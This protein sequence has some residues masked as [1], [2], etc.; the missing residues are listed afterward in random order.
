MYAK[1]VMRK[2]L[3]SGRLNTTAGMLHTSSITV[4]TQFLELTCSLCNSQC[5]SLLGKFDLVFFLP[6][7]YRFQSSLQSAFLVC[8]LRAVRIIIIFCKEAGRAFEPLF[9]QEFQ[10]RSQ[11]N[12]IPAPEP[13]FSALIHFRRGFAML[14][15]SCPS[16]PAQPVNANFLRAF[17]LYK[18]IR[19]DFSA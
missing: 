4:P 1:E 11:K 8:A 6:R 14:C 17:V 15:G 16:A 10:V 7:S 3:A 9:E 12:V 5:C 13:R 2:V 18:S 19:G